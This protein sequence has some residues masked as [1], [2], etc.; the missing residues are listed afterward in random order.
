MMRTD[1]YSTYQYGR[2]DTASLA[3]AA[4]AGEGDA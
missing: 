3:V 1:W 4:A 2:F